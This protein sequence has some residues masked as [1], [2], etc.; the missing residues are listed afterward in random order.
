MARAKVEIGENSEAAIQVGRINQLSYRNSQIFNS[1]QVANINEIV[2]S[3]A[4]ARD[5]GVAYGVD[6]EG[7]SIDFY[8][9]R[10][11]GEPVIRFSE[12]K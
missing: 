4:R 7:R 3:R 12:R 1:F 10:V 9:P 11:D 6:R 8:P 5:F 2:P